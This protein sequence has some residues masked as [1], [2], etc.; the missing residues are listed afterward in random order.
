M[1][2]LGEKNLE[3]RRGSW[4][5]GSLGVHE[6]GGACD[7]LHVHVTRPVNNPSSGPCQRWQVFFTPAS[8]L[9]FSSH[10]RVSSPRFSR[11]I[12]P[13]TSICSHAEES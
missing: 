5:L 11:R 1:F 12:A 7:H 3:L 8:W 6:D 10:P 9:L 13:N 2:N 4:G